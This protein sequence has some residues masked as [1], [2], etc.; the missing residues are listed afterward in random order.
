MATLFY[1]FAHEKEAKAENDANGPSAFVNAFA[2][3]VEMLREQ[4]A[5]KAPEEIEGQ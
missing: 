5:E 3:Q 2:Q 1:L 4:M